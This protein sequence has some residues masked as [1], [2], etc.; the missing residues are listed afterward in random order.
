MTG[1]RSIGGG[2]H[3]LIAVAVSAFL[4]STMLVAVVP[5]SSALAADPP[6][7]VR[8]WPGIRADSATRFSTIPYRQTKSV[9]VTF[10][11][12]DSAECDPTTYAISMFG[13]HGSAYVIGKFAASSVTVAPGAS[14]AL[15]VN[16]STTAK[17]KVGSAVW[18]SATIKN[19]TTQVV[20]GMSGILRVT[21]VP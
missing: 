21:V 1:T 3:G 10:Y 17:A 5:V 8:G 18:L 20:S 12:R 6:G 9:V 14:K 15:K 2:V 19:K 13:E 11:N 7:C 4:L 16:L